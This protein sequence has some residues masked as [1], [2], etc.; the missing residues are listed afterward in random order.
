MVEKIKELK[1]ML[2]R[3]FTEAYKAKIMEELKKHRNRENF[4]EYKIEQNFATLL[5]SIV[6]FGASLDQ[7]KELRDLFSNLVEK[8]I[9]PMR[10]KMEILKKG[11]MVAFFQSLIT[12]FDEV[13]TASR[14]SGKMELI[15]QWWKVFLQDIQDCLTVIYLRPHVQ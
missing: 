8:L 9:V 5:K 10:E 15:S 12:T 14:S 3:E 2:D 7:P 1:A 4:D 6:S 11:A 13:P